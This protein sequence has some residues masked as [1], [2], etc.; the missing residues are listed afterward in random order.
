MPSNRSHCQ[1]KKRKRFP[2]HSR[3]EQFWKARSCSPQG[4]ILENLAAAIYWA[5]FYPDLSLSVDSLCGVFWKI[6]PR[7]N[8]NVVSVAR[9]GLPL[10]LH[11]ILEGQTVL[12][13]PWLEVA[14]VVGDSTHGMAGAQGWHCAQETGVPGALPCCAP[15]AYCDPETLHFIYLINIEVEHFSL[16]FWPFRFQLLPKDNLQVLPQF[17][18]FLCG[19]RCP[20]ES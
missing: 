16:C 5:F 4:Q 17:C 12:C 14:G 19:Y 18:L 20:Q 6:N 13:H 3:G 10:T 8:E 9:K 7:V 2:H 15:K 11:L 1:E